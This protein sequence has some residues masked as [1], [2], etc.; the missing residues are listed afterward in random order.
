[1]SL[2]KCPN[3]ACQKKVWVLVRGDGVVLAHHNL[4]GGE[5]FVP[6]PCPQGGKPLPPG[7][8][9]VRRSPILLGGERGQT[10]GLP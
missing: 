4:P 7:A 3:R 9:A 8:E 1:M 5:L 10:G 2:V 6:R